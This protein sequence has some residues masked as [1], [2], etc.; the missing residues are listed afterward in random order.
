MP[1]LPLCLLGLARL[2][3][4]SEPLGR[5]ST[6]RPWTDVCLQPLPRL[7]ELKVGEPQRALFPSRSS[8]S[9]SSAPRCST[10]LL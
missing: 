8:C 6:K 2:T 10:W 3:E 7:C 1:F 9:S 4:A 5:C